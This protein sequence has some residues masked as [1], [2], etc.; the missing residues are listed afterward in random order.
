MARLT[1][2]IDFPG[3]ES[4]G[5]GKIRLLEM[6]QETGSIS[7]AGKSMNMSY[8]RAWLLVDAL[9]Q[10]FKDP[11]VATKLGGKAGGGASL[12]KLGTELIGHYREMERLA[13]AALVS[14]IRSIESALKPQGTMAEAKTTS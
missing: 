4:I 1:I 6:I 5:P 12:T 11:V 10:E 7:A 8:R 14:P 13:H 3:A 9:N 2:R